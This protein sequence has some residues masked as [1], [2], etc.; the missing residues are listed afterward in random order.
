MDAIISFFRDDISGFY[1]FIY[2]A[3]L[4]FFILAIIGYLVTQS[5]LK[6]RMSNSEK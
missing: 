1:G 2:S 4:I 6:A 3:V 5:C